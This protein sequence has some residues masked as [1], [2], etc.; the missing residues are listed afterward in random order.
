MK[1]GTIFHRGQKLKDKII[2]AM[3]WLRVKKYWLL[4]PK[5]EYKQN[6]FY[7]V[8]GMVL[9]LI[10][11]PVTLYVLTIEK[12]VPWLVEIINKKQDNKID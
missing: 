10:A 2:R 11:V 5:K 4:M 8:T 6:L 1:N 12:F 7:N 3:A 9:W